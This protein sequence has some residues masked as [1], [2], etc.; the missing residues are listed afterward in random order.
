MNYI[1]WTIFLVTWGVTSCPPSFTC[2]PLDLL[3]PTRHRFIYVI[4][5]GAASSTLSNQLISKRFDF[6]PGSLAGMLIA[7]V[8]KFINVQVPKLDN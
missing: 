6:E 8:G 5:F 1:A 2:S 3:V 7:Q 4:I